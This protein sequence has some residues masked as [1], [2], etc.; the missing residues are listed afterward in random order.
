MANTLELIAS[1]TVGAGGSASITFSSI[2][3]TYTD[4]V[5][6]VSSRSDVSSTNDYGYIQLNSDT[7]SANYPY[8]QLIGN[9][10]V[11]GSNSGTLAGAA[12]LR[13]SAA[14]ATASVF[15]SNEIYIS[16]YLSTVVKS[17]FADGVS[18]NNASDATQSMWASLWNPATQVAITSIVLK[19]GSGNFVQHS[20]AY[21][22]GVKSS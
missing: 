19:A 16:N 18:E 1:S 14:T 2:P 11:T 20:T 5:L 10:S 21:L 8:R 22:Y 4:L 9:G 6:K 17:I 13:M 15:G 3:N 7:T 12:S